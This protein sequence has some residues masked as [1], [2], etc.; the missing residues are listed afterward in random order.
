[1]KTRLLTVIVFALISFVIPTASASCAAPLFGDPGPCF[2]SF[3]VRV[4]DN[5]VPISLTEQSIMENFARNIETT[6]D[7]WQTSDRNWAHVDSELEFPAI[8][9]TEFVADGMKH[10]R[11]AKWVDKITIS[12]FLQH[13]F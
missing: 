2:D 11:I 7:D 5:N 4:D 3:S 9:C 1:M 6:Y 12:S 10:Y 8:I 13:Q